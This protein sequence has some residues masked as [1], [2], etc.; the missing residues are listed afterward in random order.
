MEQSNLERLRVPQPLPYKPPVNNANGSVNYGGGSPLATPTPIISANNNNIDD[1][2]YQV[3][4]SLSQ[5]EFSPQS[6]PPQP[7]LKKPEPV[8]QLKTK[9][10]IIAERGGSFR[11]FIISICVVTIV[12]SLLVAYLQAAKAAAASQMEEKYQTEVAPT[13]DSTLFT[14]K[15]TAVNNVGEQV[16]SL[17]SSLA[18]RI[19]FSPFFTELERV[20]YKDVRYTKVVVNSEGEVA[21]EGVA[22]SFTALA[23]ASD[24]LGTSSKFTS[25][26]LVSAE[27]QADGQVFFVI[28][29]A[30]DPTLF[31]STQ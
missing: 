18:Q 17:Q 1:K 16:A 28:A 15:E 11:Y 2:S 4:R 8:S 13:L 10:V 20:T 26:E 22:S 5:P 24:A 27:K 21:I 23:K 30:L 6:Q 7:P 25:V 3:P 14:Q 29:V 12:S 31:K 9:E 19:Y